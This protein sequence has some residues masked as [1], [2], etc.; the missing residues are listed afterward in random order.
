MF[1]NFEI[2]NFNQKLF[3]F[4]K[5]AENLNFKPEEILFDQTS[6]K[7]CLQIWKRSNLKIL[8]KIKLWKSKKND[9]KFQT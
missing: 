5:L 2:W 8:L 9:E 6:K 4:F 7:S 1:R 3:D